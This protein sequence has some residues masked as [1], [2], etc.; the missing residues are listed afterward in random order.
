MATTTTTV[1][2]AVRDPKTGKLDKRIEEVAVVR[3]SIRNRDRRPA[4]RTFN[5]VISGEVKF[6]PG[7]VK[8]LEVSAAMAAEL[9]ARKDRSWE[10]TTATPS[11]SA[12][13]DEEA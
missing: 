12:D 7:E 8:T 9:R 6:R 13:D 2:M 11:T 4:G 1:E 3:I 5:D 10:L